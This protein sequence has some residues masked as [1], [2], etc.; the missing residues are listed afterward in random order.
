MHHHRCDGSDER[1][2]MIA[3]FAN[4]DVSESVERRSARGDV[5]LLSDWEVVH[6]SG[7]V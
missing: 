1:I 2:A 4:I 6:S 3:I 5:F 7:L